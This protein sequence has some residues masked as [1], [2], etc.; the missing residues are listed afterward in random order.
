MYLH[1]PADYYFDCV[2]YM[3][4]KKAAAVKN[5]A[6]SFVILE[7]KYKASVIYMN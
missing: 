5:G 4:Q 2:C 1:L 7:I 3:L 6:F